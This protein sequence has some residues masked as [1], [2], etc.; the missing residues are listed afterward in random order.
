MLV[1][2]IYGDVSGRSPGI[3]CSACYLGKEAEWQVA[4]EVWK[5]VLEDAEAKGFHATDFYNAKGEFDNDK[6]RREVTGRGMQPGG[7]LHNRFA[8]RFCGVA[9]DAGL[10]GFAFAVDAA[11]FLEIEAPELEKESRQNKATDPRTAAIFG[12]VVSVNEFLAKAGHDKASNIQVVF[13]HEQGAGKFLEFFSESKERRERWTYW[14]HSFTTSGKSI[15]PLQMAD[16]LAHEGWRR[17]KE[18]ES[19]NPRALRKS[20][21]RMLGDGKV[22]LRW[23]GLSHCQTN[24][25]N[26]R[27]ALAQYPDGLMPPDYWS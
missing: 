16:L 11:A 25:A 19:K 17:A 10:V 4:T 18:V 5:A 9:H 3:V 15:A 27:A 6:W 20:F 1:N 24:A 12:N 8:E 2:Y 23:H 26:I 21:L 14:F 7:E 13:E 22:E